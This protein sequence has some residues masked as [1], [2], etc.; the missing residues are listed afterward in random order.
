VDT[1][2]GLIHYNRQM[3]KKCFSKKPGGRV[4][5]QKF[6]MDDEEGCW[7]AEKIR[8]LHLIEKVPYDRMAILYRTNFLSLPFEKALRSAKVPY[9]LKGDRG[10]FDRKEIQDINCYLISTVHQQDAL[11]FQRIINTPKRGIG[12]KTFQKILDF[13]DG[14]KT[15][16]EAGRKAMEANALP[17][18]AHAALEKLISFLESLRQEQPYS[19]ILRVLNETG[20]EEYLANYSGGAESSQFANRMEN[21]EFLLDLAKKKVSLEQYLEEITLNIDDQE[22]KDQ[23]GEQVTLATV[24]GAKGLEWEAVFVVGV[25]EE[26]FPHWRSFSD[27]TEGIQEERRLMYVAMTRAERY[28]FLTHAEWR[29][30]KSREPSQFLWQANLIDADGEFLAKGERS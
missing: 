22:D 28:L 25:E 29:A 23:K 14:D 8:A 7:I 13:Q 12:A 18:K 5:V 4:E 6:F 9:F 24:H 11:S 16:Q 10:F 26:I 21:I 3:P 27:G 2:E 20:Y 1:A 17:K 30:G 15:I 19:A